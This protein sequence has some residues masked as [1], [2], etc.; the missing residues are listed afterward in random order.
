MA[1]SR[2]ARSVE[3]EIITYCTDTCNEASRLKNDIGPLERT[4]TQ[5]LMQRYLPRLLS[6]TSAGPPGSIRSG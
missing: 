2:P 1:V 4:R 3:E 6:W 5:E